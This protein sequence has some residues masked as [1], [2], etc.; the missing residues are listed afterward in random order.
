MNSQSTFKLAP[1]TLAIA[2]ALYPVQVVMAQE[3]K[4]DLVLEEVLVTAT[5]RETSLQ[6]VPQSITAFTSEEIKSRNLQTLD[7]LVAA[8]PSLGLVSSQPGRNDLV[9]RGISS[10]SG[11]Y[12]TDTQV[13]VYLDDSS[14]SLISQQPWPHF[15]DIDHVESLPGPQGTLYGSASQTGTTRIITRKPTTE[16]VQGEA[17]AEVSSTK[18]GDMSY[19]LN[20][21]INIPI[22]DSFAIRAVAY[23]VDNG[24]WIDN[25]PY[26][27]YRGPTEDGPQFDPTNADVVDDNINTQVL[28]GGRIAALWE[29]SDDL[30]A[31]LA[32]ITEDSLSKGT[33][34][35]DPYFGDFEIVRFFDEYNEDNWTNIAF[36][37]D[38]DL[39]FAS[40]LSVTSIFDRHIQ[41]E[42][43]RTH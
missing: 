35:S 24:G 33:W 8:L 10:G 21:M 36:T 15:V 9:Y 2:A 23:R 40:F 26:S 31:S 39:G 37:I 19:E 1:L 22:G 13:A 17:F 6:V 25:V 27:A 12:Y 30:S 20:G 34:N 16:G 42:W 43:D 38:A 7:D 3:E 41:Y 11:E 29:L 4:D 5:M 14:I 28:N 18:G 32:I